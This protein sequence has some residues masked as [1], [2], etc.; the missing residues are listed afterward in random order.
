MPDRYGFDHLPTWGIIEHRCIEEGCDYPGFG[1]R[2]TEKERKRHFESHKRPIEKQRQRE[3]EK[4]RL[5]NL[6]KARKA[7]RQKEEHDQ[8]ESDCAA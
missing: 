3:I 7:R 1:V 2:L 5:A 8:T 6:A 4:T